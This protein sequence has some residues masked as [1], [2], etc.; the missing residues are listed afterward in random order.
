MVKIEKQSISCDEFVMLESQH[1][2]VLVLINFNQDL[3]MVQ[4][5]CLNIVGCLY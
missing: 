2:K 1:L 3:K 4:K 5:Y